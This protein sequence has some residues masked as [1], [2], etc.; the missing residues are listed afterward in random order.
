MLSP[1]SPPAWATADVDPKAH[2]LDLAPYELIEP[3]IAF[4]NLRTAANWFE[5]V[6]V[7]LGGC[8]VSWMLIGLLVA[9][10]TGRL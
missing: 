4:E 5:R 6:T 9:W 7:I 1:Y 2:H 3:A 8:L 10:R